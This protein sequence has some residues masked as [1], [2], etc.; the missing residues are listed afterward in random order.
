VEVAAIAPLERA[1]EEQHRRGRVR[2]SHINLHHFL[3]EAPAMHEGARGSPVYCGL[4]KLGIH[5]AL[6][7]GHGRWKPDRDLV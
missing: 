2:D 4:I 5:S 6:F 7:M 1:G 3:Y